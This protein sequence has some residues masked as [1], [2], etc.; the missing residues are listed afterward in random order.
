MNYKQ[1]FSA[2]HEGR[3][4]GRYITLEH[5]KPLLKSYENVMEISTVG[6]SELGKEIPLIRIG[7]GKHVVL[8]WSQMHGNESTTTKAVFDFIKFVAQKDFFQSEIKLFLDH[9][10]FFILPILNPDGA[11][12]YTRENANGIDLNRDAQ[13]LSQRESIALRSVFNSIQPDLCLNLHD[14]RSIYGLDTGAASAVSFLAPSANKE[15]SLT[16]SRELAMSHIVR[17]NRVLQD[18]L[19]GQ[20]GRYDDCFNANC[21]GDTFQM[22]G[23]P[24]ILFEAGHYKED[25]NREN[26]RLL[27]FNAF[28]GLFGFKK[29]LGKSENFNHYFNI[30]QNR[31]NHNDIIL[32]R[33]LLKGYDALVDIAIQYTESLVHAEVGFIAVIDK[34]GDCDSTFG[35]REV[36][37]KGYSLLINSQENIELGQYVNTIVI[38]NNESDVI[39]LNK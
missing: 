1:W 22:A 33:V 3:L 5:I 15:R 23:V 9:Y 36:D 6:C 12:L 14:Q 31:V 19:P 8:G 17:I 7:K 26:T 13:D 30:P 2:H 11:H 10:S 28:L 32:R 29:L 20:V 37:V 18:I 27:L 16:K 4:K 34:I 24:T 25:Y 21:V 38:K 39:L 35:H